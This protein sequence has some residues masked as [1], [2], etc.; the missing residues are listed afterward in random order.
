MV[1][2]SPSSPLL[3]RSVSPYVSLL[4]ISRQISWAGLLNGLVGIREA[5]RRANHAP[6]ALGRHLLTP[7]PRKKTDHRMRSPGH[8]KLH[9]TAVRIPVDSHVHDRGLHYLQTPC[10]SDSDVPRELA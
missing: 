2:D 9:R 5:G 7:A 8:Q 1:Q 3:A 6:T 4:S 10:T